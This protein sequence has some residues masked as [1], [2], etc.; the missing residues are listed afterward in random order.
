MDPL[1]AQMIHYLGKMPFLGEFRAYAHVQAEN[2][3]RGT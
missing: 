1:F 3:Q 2:M